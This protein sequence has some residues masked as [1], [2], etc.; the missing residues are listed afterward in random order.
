MPLQHADRAVHAE[1][2]QLLLCMADELLREGLGGHAVHLMQSVRQPCKLLAAA[3]P[4][5]AL[6][7]GEQL[8]NECKLPA[9]WVLVN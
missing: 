2:G 7:D 5:P 8:L 3:L 9:F 1:A 6:C 4:Q